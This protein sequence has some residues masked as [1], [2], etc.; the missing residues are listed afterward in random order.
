[1][2]AEIPKLNP[3]P[4]P[5]APS[6]STTSAVPADGSQLGGATKG[7]EGL[8]CG[9]G[10]QQQVTR[11]GRGAPKP[12]SWRVPG[13]KSLFFSENLARR[14]GD[15][16]NWDQWQ[17]LGAG[18]APAGDSRLRP[19]VSGEPGGSRGSPKSPGGLK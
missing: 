6:S 2:A 12:C 14:G 4:V 16:A 1:M 10:E 15:G 3:P 13:P 5:S 11:E 18:G 17:P 8:V 9:R 19:R 7:L